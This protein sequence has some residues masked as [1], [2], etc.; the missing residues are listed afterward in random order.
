MKFKSLM[1]IIFSFLL[2]V[3]LTSCS[4][5]SASLDSLLIPPKVDD[6][7][8]KGTWNVENFYYMYKTNSTVGPKIP[9]KSYLFI[10]DNYLRIN[11][12]LVNYE[13]YKIKTTNLSDYMRV[14]FKISDFS[15]LNL[16]DREINIYTIQDENKNLYEFLMYDENTLLFYY[17][18]DIMYVYRKTSEKI[19]KNLE[20]YVKNNYKNNVLSGG[21]ENII[22]TGFLISFKS[23]REVV[24]SS[25]PKSLYK[26]VWFYQSDDGKYSYK[27]FDDIIIPKNG[28][29]LSIKVEPSEKNSLYEKI[30]VD[31]KIPNTNMVENV[32]KNDNTNELFINQFIDI[33]YVNENFIGINYDQNTEY[34]GEIYTDKIAMLSIDE[35][36]IE[37][38]LKFSDIFE[39][40]KNEFFISRKKALDFINDE[41]L[42]MYDE[43]IREDS[44]K[45]LRYA[46]GWF[47][48]GRIN[49][50]TGYDVLPIDFDIEVLPNKKLVN[51]NDLSI[52]LGQIKLKKPEVLDAFVSPNRDIIV[53]LTKENI[54]IYKIINDKISNNVIGEFSIKKDDIVILS[55]WYLNEEASAINKLLEEIK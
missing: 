47:L 44:F 11:D 9:L 55:E 32:I 20:E 43:E 25:I 3:F 24:D 14:K 12:I 5:F 33:T 31:K 48:K 53:T 39:K 54:Y 50:K 15:F 38:K 28:E 8:V 34:L 37:R 19:D 16:D 30:I 10:S 1:K 17:D 46:G 36:Y 27:I 22:N 49:P 42:K 29:I 23:E 2:L 26:S 41:N 6:I 40:N 21:S 45:L 4:T 35:P 52:N 7:L 18:D 13:N 51:D